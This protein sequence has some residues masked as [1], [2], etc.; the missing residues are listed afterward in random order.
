MGPMETDRNA[1]EVLDRQTCID[2]LRSA[3]V[4]RVGLSVDALPVVLPVNFVLL[5]DEIVIGSGPGGKLRS[6]VTGNVVAFEADDWDPINHLGWSVLVRGH[7]RVIEDEPELSA[8][9]ELP[10]RPWGMNGDLT[11]LGVRLDLVTGR[12]L[13]G[14]VHVAGRTGTATRRM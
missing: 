11:Y 5:D 2:L 12:R 6:A 14:V 4:G 9:R 7:S 10:L 3:P 13:R 8:V 1:L